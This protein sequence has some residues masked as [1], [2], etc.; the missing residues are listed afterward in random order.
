MAA[1]D[2]IIVEGCLGTVYL[3]KKIKSEKLIS[4]DRRV[5]TDNEIIG[6]F[7]CYLKKFCDDNGTD[8]LVITGNNGKRIFE[9]KL[10]KE[11]HNEP[12]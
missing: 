9:A 3:A 2:Y 7:E 1:K 10:L 11:N 4:Q 6:M 12:D 5:I 8:T